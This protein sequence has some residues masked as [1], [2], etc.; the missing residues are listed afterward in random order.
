MNA[1]AED[2]LKKL[3]STYTYVWNEANLKITEVKNFK[4]ESSVSIRK[5]KKIVAYDYQIMLAWQ[6]D[7]LDKDGQSYAK[8]QGT[9]EFPELSNEEADDWEIRV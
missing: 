3:L 2:H 9:F 4:G 1:W 6:I 7:M 5:G 8:T